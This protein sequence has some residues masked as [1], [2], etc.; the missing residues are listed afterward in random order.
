MKIFFRRVIQAL[1][2]LVVAMVSALTAMRYAIHGREVAV[3]D[4]TGKTPAE[5]RR[6]AE[7][8]GL[9]VLV[10]RQYYSS[11]VPE[12]RILLQLPPA[13]TKVR[14]GWDLRLAASLGP[15]RVEIPS[16]LGQSER[17]AEMN[18]RRRGLDLVS[19]ARVTIPGIEAQ[20]VVSQSPVPKANNVL[21][22][23]I[24]ILVAEAPQAETFVM[25]NFAGQTVA[26]ATQGVVDGGLHMGAITAAGQVG[27]AGGHSTGRTSPGSVIVSQSPA[28]GEKVTEGTVVD[29]QVQ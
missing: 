19:V 8:E 15:Q 27:E 17:V 21:A 9:Q 28:A 23:K 5:A 24:S 4:L 10:E 3:P 2:L 13:G 25:P 7:Q 1:I 14:R 11:A 12:G 18:I 29:F 6:M 26:G 22:P 20:Q 16:V